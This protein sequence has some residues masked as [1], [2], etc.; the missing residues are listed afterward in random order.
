M[1]QIASS[2]PNQPNNVTDVSGLIDIQ[3]DY[4]AGITVKS[5]DPELSDKITTL[6][7]ELDKLYTNFKNANISS[8]DVL[9]KQQEVYDIIDTEKE[10]LL[11]KKQGIDNALVGKKRAI[12]LNES[13]RLRQTQYTRMKV[14]V[15]ITLVVCIVLAFLGKRFPV[16]P[17]II[18]TLLILISLLVG[19]LYCLFIYSVISSRSKLNYNELNLPGL[20][21]PSDDD[22][23]ANRN[24]AGKAGDLLGSINIPGCIGSSCCNDDTVWSQT[25]SKCVALT[26]SEVPSDLQEGTLPETPDKKEAFAPFKAMKNTSLLVNSP[27]EYE[28]YGRV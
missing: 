26:P 13:Y 4:L 23:A 11:L 17:S 28:S 3:K 8:K 27:N 6:Q 25:K 21:V 18:I 12:N 1:A 9:D 24:A 5:D 19:V 20:N 15:V 10:R 7:G 16:I 14:T 22:L 2:S